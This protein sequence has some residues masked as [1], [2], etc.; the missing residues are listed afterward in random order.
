LAILALHFSFVVSRVAARLTRTVVNHELLI[1][2]TSSCFFLPQTHDHPYRQF[3]QELV[4]RTLQA[5]MLPMRRLFPVL[6]R[7][8]GRCDTRAQSPNLGLEVKDPYSS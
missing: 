5:S 6:Q 2:K 4:V 7:W 8:H 1:K 3:L